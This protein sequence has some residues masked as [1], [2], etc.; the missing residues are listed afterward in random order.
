[1][2]AFRKKNK[3][4]VLLIWPRRETILKQKVS[5]EKVVC[6]FYFFKWHTE[7]QWKG[8]DTSGLFI[9]V[10][11]FLLSQFSFF[12]LVLPCLSNLMQ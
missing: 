4:C 3:K 11:I 2:Y 9:F 5:F 8:S 6:L 7:S 1:M 10:T 12:L